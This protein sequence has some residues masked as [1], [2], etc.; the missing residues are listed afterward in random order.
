[1]TSAACVCYGRP[2]AL[3]SV[4]FMIP[5]GVGPG[6]LGPCVEVGTAPHL[7]IGER[8]LAG[9]HRHSVRQPHVAALQVERRQCHGAREGHQAQH[10]REVRHGSWLSSRASRHVLIV[11]GLVHGG[12]G[13]VP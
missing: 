8:L 2:L 13:V 3:V 4:R 6:V 9:H 12:A 1:M 5:I 10:C 7:S 11:P